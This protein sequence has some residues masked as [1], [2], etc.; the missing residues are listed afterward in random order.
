MKVNLY[1]A[2]N[3]KVQHFFFNFNLRWKMHVNFEIV[4]GDMLILIFKSF[5]LESYAINIKML[6]SVT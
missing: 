2:R 1:I 5:L 4:N 3:M 6:I